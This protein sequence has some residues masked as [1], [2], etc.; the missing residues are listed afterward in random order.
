MKTDPDRMNM[1]QKMLL[2]FVSRVRSTLLKKLQSHQEAEVVT[3]LV[4]GPLF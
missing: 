2:K 3:C 1:T 4:Q